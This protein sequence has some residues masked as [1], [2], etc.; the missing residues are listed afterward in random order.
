MT[1]ETYTLP[2]LPGVSWDVLEEAAAQERAT[3]EELIDCN[4]KGL[5]S[6]QKVP[7]QWPTP[8]HIPIKIP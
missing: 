1:V 4:A 5:L 2:A 7:G 8:L 3:T 6:P